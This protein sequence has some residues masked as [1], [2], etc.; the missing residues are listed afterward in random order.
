MITFPPEISAVSNV[1]MVNLAELTKLL[2]N[3]EIFFALIEA[4][5]VCSSN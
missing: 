2:Q 1:A 5:I 4:K 3:E